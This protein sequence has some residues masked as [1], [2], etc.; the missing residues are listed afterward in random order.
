M[1]Y[2]NKSG[3]TLG[4]N[5]PNSN[6]IKPNLKRAKMNANNFITKDYRKNDDFTIQQ[7]KPNFRNAQN[8]RKLNFNKGLQKKRCFSVQKNK[9][10]QTQFQIGSQKSD[11]RSQ[12]PDYLLSFLCFLFSVFCFLMQPKLLNFHHKNSLTV[13]PNSVK[14]RFLCNERE[15]FY[16]ELYGKERKRRA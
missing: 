8:E 3:W 4:Q 9:P 6:P 14:Y 11:V 12:K 13:G 5:K 2:E 7:N 15:C 10:K 16:E 1:A